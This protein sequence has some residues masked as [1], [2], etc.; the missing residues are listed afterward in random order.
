M[1]AKWEFCFQFRNSLSHIA[2]RD[3]TYTRREKSVPSPGG[4]Q[5]IGLS[6]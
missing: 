3:K 5:N 2:P 4:V 1:S 6:K